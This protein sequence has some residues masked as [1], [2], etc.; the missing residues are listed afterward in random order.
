MRH[1]P[2]LSILFLLVGLQACVTSKIKSVKAQEFTQKIQKPL[3]VYK[4]DSR[5][6]EFY[7]SM[8]T[9]LGKQLAPHRVKP[10]FYKMPEVSLDPEADLQKF[11]SETAPDCVVL[12]KFTG[13]V[14]TSQ[15]WGMS[16]VS[17]LNIEFDMVLPEKGEHVWKASASVRGSVDIAGGGRMARD[18]VK[19]M[20]ADGVIGQ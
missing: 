15:G 16:S 17:E 4:P 12:V 18:V 13:G 7:R 9:E 1:L 14:V 11:A 8:T 6:A 5:T 10:S 20:L 19:K 2:H 3:F